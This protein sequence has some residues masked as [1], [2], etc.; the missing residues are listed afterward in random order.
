MTQNKMPNKDVEIFK[1]CI[2]DEWDFIDKGI[3]YLG[4]D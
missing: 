3:H 1:Q 4:L 2:S